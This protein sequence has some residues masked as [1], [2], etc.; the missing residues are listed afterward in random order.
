MRIARIMV[1]LTTY[2][3]SNANRNFV[4]DFALIATRSK[5]WRYPPFFLVGES[6]LHTQKTLANW[7]G[8]LLVSASGFEPETL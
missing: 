6:W 5:I 3:L 1:I 4:C 7:L 8:F 2:H